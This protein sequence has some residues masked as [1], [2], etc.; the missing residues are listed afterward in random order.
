[1]TDEVDR[2]V[3]AESVE[4]GA[5]V[6]GHAT[7]VK[8]VVRRN[9]AVS[10]GPKVR[11]PTVANVAEL[12]GDPGVAPAME[13]GGVHEKERWSF[14]SEIMDGELDAVAGAR[15]ECHRS[16]SFTK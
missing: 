14:A 16:P 6:V 5:E 2:L 10:V 9:G 15:V 1:M 7:P 12:L 3:D 4:H 11:C 13:A 8:A